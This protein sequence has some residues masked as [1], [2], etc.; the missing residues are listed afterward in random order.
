M[1][2]YSRLNNKEPL[3]GKPLELALDLLGHLPDIVKKLQLGQ[4]LTDYEAHYL[5][6]SVLVHARV[7]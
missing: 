4:A 7:R 3:T 1:S 5:V 6:D 2:Y